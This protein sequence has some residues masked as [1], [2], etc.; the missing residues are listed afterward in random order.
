MCFPIS[1]ASEKHRKEEADK[2][3]KEGQADSKGVYH[4][5]QTVGNACGVSWPPHARAC[6]RA[7]CVRVCVRVVGAG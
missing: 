4:T 1:E 2:I 5:L 7:C 6:V 3:A